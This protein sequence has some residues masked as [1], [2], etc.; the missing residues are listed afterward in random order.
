MHKNYNQVINI[1]TFVFTF[2]FFQTLKFD[3]KKQAGSNLIPVSTDNEVEFP[4]IVL[5]FFR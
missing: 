5:F 4:L 3:E 2:F 1:I